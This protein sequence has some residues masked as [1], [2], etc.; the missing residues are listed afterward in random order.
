M[1]IGKQRSVAECRL[2]HLRW[3]QHLCGCTLTWHKINRKCLA[4]VIS[5]KPA[6]F[7]EQSTGDCL[8]HLNKTAYKIVFLTKFTLPV[9]QK[10]LSPFSNEPY[11]WIPMCSA[12]R[13]CLIFSWSVQ[14]LNDKWLSVITPSCNIRS[15]AWF[16]E[17]WS[18]LHTLNDSVVK[19]L[20]HFH[21][22]GKWF[23]QTA[24]K[25]FWTKRLTL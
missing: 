24:G 23:L 16:S 12:H 22:E 18:E 25:T 3:N 20:F 7:S 11:N 9:G 13:L 10:F 8:S 2:G 15:P 6:N 17:L 4:Y 1:Y 14:I 19:I 5:W 21:H